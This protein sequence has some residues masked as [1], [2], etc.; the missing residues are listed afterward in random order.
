MIDNINYYGLDW[1]ATFITCI[2]I[3]KIGNRDKD[4]F[5][6]MMSGNI[7]WFVVGIM[8]DSMAMLLANTIFFSINLRAILKWS[9]DIS[10][11]KLH[12]IK[13]MTCS[14]QRDP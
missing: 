7:I 2:A 6:L 9:K 10:S 13:N 1:V 11:Q 5:I 3:I 4:G 8:A 14:C 12:S